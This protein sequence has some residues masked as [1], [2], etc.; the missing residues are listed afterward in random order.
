VWSPVYGK[1]EPITV[2]NFGTV[3]AL[4]AEFVTLLV[5]LE[6]VRGIPGKLVRIVPEE[7]G[8]SAKAYLY[9]TP[10]A[11]CSFFFAEAGQSWSVGK[12]ASDAE[13][14]CW[15]RQSEGDEQLLVFANGSYVEIEGRRVLDCKRQI[16]HCEMLICDGHTEVRASEPEALLREQLTSN[17]R[18]TTSS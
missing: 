2:L 8:A 14:V 4:P 13:F 3:T 5:S 12:V 15:Q 6:E 7:A 16:S 9:R 1:K 11:E 10:S 17:S 18:R